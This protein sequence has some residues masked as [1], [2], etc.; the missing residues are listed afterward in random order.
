MIPITKQ[1][2]QINCYADKNNPVW[3]VIHETD[4]YTAGSGAKAHSK[5]HNN[6]NLNTSVHYYV[7]DHSIYQTLSHSDGAWAVGHQY[8]T[9]PVPGVSNYNSINI[10]ICVNPD[11]DYD[12]ARKNCIDLVK[13][14]IQETGIA[15][16]HV[17]RHYDAKLKWCPRKMMDNP[18]LWTEFKE[19][20]IAKKSGW[21]QECGGWRFY[22]G[23]TGNYISND[24]YWDSKN[25]YW[26]DG[27]GMMVSDTW[28]TG[29]DGKWYYLS[30]DGSMAKNQWII[31][32]NRL[33]KVT[34]DGS[35]F[36]GD[37]HLKT[38][39]N[40]ALIQY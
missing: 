28:K 16:D 19:Q 17:I 35:M 15:A 26:F 20:L 37:I 10:E 38:D 11:S 36:Q 25:W 31:W 23:D 7:D 12:I 34:E 1:I 18:K 33:Y 2:K 30:S 3:I 9:P 32:N 29:S 40:G 27:A 39:S 22:L 13:Y 24:W 4:N 5:A 14:L 21:H 6:G 8:G